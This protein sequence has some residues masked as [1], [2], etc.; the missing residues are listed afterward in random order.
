[1]NDTTLLAPTRLG[2]FVLAGMLT[3][4]AGAQAQ[5]TVGPMAKDAA[6]PASEIPSL[7]TRL[8]G[9]EAQTPIVR[10]PWSPFRYCSAPDYPKISLRN[11]EQGVVDVSFLIAENGQVI[12]ARVRKSSG[13]EALDNATIRALLKCRFAPV[14]MHGVP[15][16]VWIGTSYQF[17][18]Y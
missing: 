2:R 16:Q 17:D 1:M 8:P 15:V 18:L 12:D 5:D 6:V 3:A 7:L 13:F 14:A 4:C 11:E 9:F 10:S